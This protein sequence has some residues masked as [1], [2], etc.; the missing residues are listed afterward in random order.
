MDGQAEVRRTTNGQASLT[1][2]TTR[3]RAVYASLP[4]GPRSGRLTQDVDPPG[5][6]SLCVVMS[7]GRHA[8]ANTGT[9]DGA[10]STKSAA[11]RVQ[12]KKVS[13]SEQRRIETPVK[14]D[15]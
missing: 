15:S 8:K 13:S 7:G 14:N 3:S 11:V 10:A 1:A 2:D 9:A 6:D 5:F 4:G 12:P